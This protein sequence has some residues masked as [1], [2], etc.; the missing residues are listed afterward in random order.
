MRYRVCLALCLAVELLIAQQ[1]DRDKS[2][3]IELHKADADVLAVFRGGA[4]AFPSAVQQSI[5]G[6]YLGVEYEMLQ[7][8]GKPPQQEVRRIGLE[9]LREYIGHVAAIDERE[10]PSLRSIFLDKLGKGALT[11]PGQKR[12]GMIVVESSPAPEEVLVNSEHFAGT[13]GKLCVLPGSYTVIVK[14]PRL[15]ACTSHVQLSAADVKTVSC[16]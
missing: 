7:A 8:S 11:F 16:R 14:R 3:F 4:T 15:A 2:R 12:Y 6:E 9:A 10:I 1:A 5:V 13:V